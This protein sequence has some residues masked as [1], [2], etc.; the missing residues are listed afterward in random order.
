V[1]PIADHN[2]RRS[3]PVVNVALIIANVLM[4]FWEASLGPELERAL[5]GVAFIPARFW[6]APL[7]PFNISFSFRSSR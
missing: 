1:L 7:A 6:Y 5:F 2:P 3:T 4:F